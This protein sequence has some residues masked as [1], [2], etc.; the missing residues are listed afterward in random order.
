MLIHFKRLTLPF[1][2]TAILGGCTHYTPPPASDVLPEAI[3]FSTF[4]R[5]E[6]ARIISS[7]HLNDQHADDEKL[8]EAVRLYPDFRRVTSERMMAGYPLED[9]KQMLR[10]VL[11]RR[12]SQYTYSDQQ[13]FYVY[14]PPARY[15]V[16]KLNYSV[17]DQMVR[18]QVSPVLYYLSPP[19]WPASSMDLTGSE[20]QELVSRLDFV[21]RPHYAAIAAQPPAVFAWIVVPPEQW[22][23]LYA[24]AEASGQ[25][26]MLSHRGG[27]IEFALGPCQD[28][29]PPQLWRGRILSCLLPTTAVHFNS[30]RLSGYSPRKASYEDWMFRNEPPFEDAYMY[31]PVRQHNRPDASS[32]R[33]WSA[34]V[35]SAQ[36]EAI[37]SVPS[38]P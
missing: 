12:T 17:R 15:P 14:V 5:Q 21:D 19:S 1:A 26:L 30:I 16:D 2:L 6:K 37:P 28:Y 3:D 11:E 13:R 29:E 31:P 27:R 7:R 9:I 35:R 10:G 18:V 34:P 8:L 33:T 23:E 36:P 20:P 4:T 38:L 22:D 25:P 24:R 32:V